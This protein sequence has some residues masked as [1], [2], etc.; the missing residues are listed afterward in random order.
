[1]TTTTTI[2]K[3]I[4]HLEYAFSGVTETIDILDSLE[5]DFELR[6]TLE[7]IQADIQKTIDTLTNQ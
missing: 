4:S 7:D 6:Y 1:M 5:L 3:A 2:R